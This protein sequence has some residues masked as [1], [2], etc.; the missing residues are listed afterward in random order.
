MSFVT[1]VYYLVIFFKKWLIYYPHNVSV[2]QPG[3][4]PGHSREQIVASGTNK[5]QSAAGSNMGSLLEP[6]KTGAVTAT[7]TLVNNVA[8]SPSVPTGNHSNVLVA[9][10]HN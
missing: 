5:S 4:S 1:P 9:E 6:L 2:E 10:S 3:Q 8:S 7:T